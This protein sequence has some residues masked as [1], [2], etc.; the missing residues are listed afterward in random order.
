MKILPFNQAQVF[1]LFR[2]H[3]I[4]FISFYNCFFT[5]IVRFFPIF[6]RISH[7]V[8]FCT[9]CSRIHLQKWMCVGCQLPFE[10]YISIQTHKFTHTIRIE[11]IVATIKTNRHTYTHTHRLTTIGHIFILVVLGSLNGWIV[12]RYASKQRRTQSN[13]SFVWSV[14]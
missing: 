8:H 14:S 9:L 11:W 1:L 10:R 12:C 3:F 2:S 5:F 6:I 7:F 13:L 4:V